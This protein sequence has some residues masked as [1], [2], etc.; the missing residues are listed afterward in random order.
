MKKKEGKQGKT[1]TN[2]KG[3]K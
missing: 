2:Q 1:E 3:N